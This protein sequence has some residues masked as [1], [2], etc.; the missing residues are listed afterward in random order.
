MQD[1]KKNKII[2]ISGPSGVGKST[3]CKQMVEKMDNTYLSISVTSRPK[4]E[5]E[6]D[7][8]EY[9]F[10]TKNE[11][12]EKI[13]KGKLLEYAEV[14]GNLYGTPKDKVDEALE[15]GKNVILEI[16]VQGAEKVKKLYPDAKMIFILPPTQK[17]LTTRING[18]G[19]EDEKAAERR[20]NGA[21]FEIAAA[22]Q[23]YKHMVINDDLNQAIDEVMQIAQD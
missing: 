16:D 9:W 10:V 8:N 1:T 23:S 12:Q 21:G 4:A 15:E 2:V 5:N 11:F 20:L 13:D 19:R 7:G 6:V 18:R 22:W 3:I 17:D 14:F